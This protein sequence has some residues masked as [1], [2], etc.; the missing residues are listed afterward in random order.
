MNVALQK[1]I[2]FLL[3][4]FLGILLKKKLGTGSEVNSLKVLILNV[5]LPATV[6]IALLK[7]EVDHSFIYL[8]FIAIAFNVLLWYSTTFFLKISKIDQKSPQGRTLQ[9]L[10]PSFAPGLSTFAII[11]EFLG[12]KVL[13]MAAFADVGNKIFVLIIMY[14]IS[15]HWYYQITDQKTKDLN[16]RWTRLKQLINALIQEPINIALIVAVTMVVLGYNFSILPLFIKESIEKMA[17]IMTPLVL[18]FI[19]LTVKLRKSNIVILLQSIFWRSGVAFLFS[20]LLLVFMPGNLPESVILLIIILP[21]SACSFWP[22]AHMSMVNE[23]QY[24]DEK[25]KIFRLDMAVNLLA[26]SLPFATILSLIICSSG[27]YFANI[28][29]VLYLGLAFITFS[30]LPFIVRAIQVWKRSVRI[31]KIKTLTAQSSQIIN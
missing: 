11:S 4:I 29:P 6:F 5:A 14:L 18:I 12:D 28:Y 24:Q 7:I 31:Y 15:M 19:G 16:Q 21:Q 23:L 1:T 30:T 20:A 3:L 17:V 25:T 13:A 27:S 9:M 2:V 22:F 10:L 8:P 26:L